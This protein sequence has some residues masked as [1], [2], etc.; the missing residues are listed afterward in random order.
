MGGACGLVLCGGL[1]AWLSARS[2][3]VAVLR[4]LI[5]RRR[6]GPQTQWRPLRKT[7]TSGLGI[8]DMSLA[9][10]AVVQL[11]VFIRSGVRWS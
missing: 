10:P 4:S 9:W 1:R 5:A 6:F 2:L 7:L 11:L 3:L 8:D